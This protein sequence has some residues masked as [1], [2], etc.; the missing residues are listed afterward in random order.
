MPGDLERLRDSG[1]HVLAAEGD[2]AGLQYGQFPVA[3]IG[4]PRGVLVGK[5]GD[6][7][8]ESLG[9]PRVD[10]DDP[11]PRDLALDREQVE[12][13][14]EAMLVGIGGRACDLLRP[15]PAVSG[16]ANDPA[17]DDGGHRA[18]AR[19]SSVRVMTLPAS[20]TLYALSRNGTASASSAEAAAR[21]LSS[22]AGRPRRASSAFAA[23][24]GLCATPPRAIRASAT[25][26][27]RRCSA[28]ATETSAKAYDAR[29]RTLRYIECA[30][31]PNGGKSTAVTSS[32]CSSVVS[33]CGSWPG[34]R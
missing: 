14:G 18:S 2:V 20:G 1:G 17:F 15:V 32:A 7:A 29:S 12:R 30:E 9:G 6:H 33:R 21:K 10:P 22:T 11:A 3:G 31:N 13:A 26:P 4:E 8:R 23:R 24:H 5:Y 34:E 19:S 16:L 25:T 27:S 28:A